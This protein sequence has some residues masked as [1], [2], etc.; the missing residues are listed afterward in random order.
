MWPRFASL[1]VIRYGSLF[2]HH[3]DTVACIHQ[4]IHSQLHF[5][6][7]RSKFRK[8]ERDNGKQSS[9]VSMNLPFIALQWDDSMGQSNIEQ[10]MRIYQGISLILYL[11]CFRH[12]PVKLLIS[13]K[14][15]SNRLF[16][17][18]FT[19]RNLPHSPPSL[20]SLL[21]LTESSVWQTRRGNRRCSSRHRNGWW[22]RLLPVLPFHLQHSSAS[23]GLYLRYVTLLL[24]CHVDQDY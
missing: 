22:S 2:S 15:K 21:V 8:Q 18:F 17:Y 12:F 10:L 13:E 9:E 6:K 23:W 11:N 7:D 14:I 4:Q 19:D 1:K 16:F 24:L 3:R 5:I 20:F